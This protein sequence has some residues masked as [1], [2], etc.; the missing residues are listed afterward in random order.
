MG[1]L[2][3]LMPSYMENERIAAI[4]R[5]IVSRK[6]AVKKIE[7]LR[8]E[9]NALD[10]EVRTVVG[11]KQGKPLAV[12]VLR[13]LT[14][15]LPKS[16][17]LMRVRVSES[18]VDIEGFASSATDILPLIEASPYF[19][20]VEFTSP[21]IRDSRMNADR[22]IIRMEFEGVKREEPKSKNGKK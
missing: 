10:E 15:V 7:S 4:D 6:E 22:F 9:Y 14:T 18:G 8:K 17:W 1:I 2:T 12:N 13:E 19:S 20:K 11:F 16:V 21:T 5:E 3:L